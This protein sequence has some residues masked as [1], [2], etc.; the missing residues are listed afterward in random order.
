MEENEQQPAGFTRGILPW[1]V[2]ALAL[3][4]Y[5]VTLNKWVSINSLGATALALDIDLWN[6]KLGRPLFY[7]VA[8]PVK[9][10]PPGSQIIGLN[11]LSA[12]CAALALAQLAR[13]VAILPQDRTHEQRLRNPDPRGLLRSQNDWLP[14]V[15][16]VLVCGF[17]LSFWEQATVATG[18]MLNLLLF[19]LVIRCLAEFRLN[20]NDKWLYWAALGQGL[21]M[22][23]NWA[24]VG[25]LPIFGLAV[26]W[27]KGMAFFRWRF[28]LTG[29]GMML[30]GMLLYFFD[31][32]LAALDKSEI[33]DFGQ[34]LTWEFVSQ[35]NPL[36]GMP[37]GR[38][39]MLSVTS[40]VPLSLL[41]IR[42]PSNFGDVSGSGVAIASFLVRA[43]HLAFFGAIVWVAFD[44]VFSP[45][46]LG[47]ELPMLT[48]YYL[49]A[50][51]V[52]YLAGYFLLTCGMQPVKRW[53]QSAGFGKLIN[54]V[55]L[56]A[57]WIGVIAVP[58]LLLRKNLPVIR[59]ENNEALRRHTNRV[60]GNLPENDVLLSG[61]DTR[62]LLLLATHFHQHPGNARL[63]APLS[64]LPKPRFHVKAAAAYPGKWPSPGDVGEGATLATAGAVMQFLSGMQASGI[65]I[66]S[67]DRMDGQI[68]LESAYPMPRGQLYELV[69]LTGTNQVDS[70]NLL[71]QIET[72]KA[73]R[74][75]TLGDIATGSKTAEKIGEI[76]SGWANT[77]GVQMQ[78]LQRADDAGWAF[79]LALELNTNNLCAKI[80]SDVHASLATN[81]PGVS[82]NITGLENEVAENRS[83]QKLL[84][85]HGPVDE[86]NVHTYFGRM[87]LQRPLARQAEQYL[88][89]AL[90]LD[91]TNFVA[92]LALAEAQLTLR[93]YAAAGTNL[94]TLAASAAGLP[95]K[96]REE[97]IRVK[98][99]L[100]SSTGAPQ[101]AA[102]SLVA[103][104][105]EFPESTDLRRTLVDV[106][107]GQRQFTNA[108]PVL[109]D[110]LKALPND[111]RAASFLASSYVEVG[112]MEDALALFAERIAK[113]PESP[114]LRLNHGSALVRAKRLDEAEA[115]YRKALELNSQLMRGH[116]G[117]ADVAKLRGN[118]NAAITHLEA[119][120]KLLPPTSP[121]AARLRRNIES[122]QGN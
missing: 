26:L 13:T 51:M 100:E 31:P 78:E 43:V 64:E 8:I 103:G 49:G 38:V 61:S 35:R 62:Q 118:T 110:L 85:R 48:F 2:A 73:V 63:I 79:A 120:V 5:G 45:R 15:F 113:E 74:E 12:I 108:V 29:F 19:A 3:I 20:Q 10:L 25:F 6:Y 39:L 81:G 28:V 109:Q 97:Y 23:T 24:M 27:I 18:E 80:N 88:Q 94:L 36:L 40:I 16:A 55:L 37:K 30:A 98:A 41:A 46:N 66:W 102:Q 86:A 119:A 72:L 60:A 69:P 101:V 106:Y 68:L 33:T 32:L 116:A 99:I 52:G 75:Q 89:R 70:T 9:W 7:L 95:A 107:I 84:Q 59:V 93:N 47:Y 50:L 114:V 44:P 117:L 111:S 4:V 65:P 21:G 76:Y 14:P 56:G 67:V 105:K 115:E 96:Q 104:L 91:G 71:E 121:D 112:R 11:F 1:A 22:A 34:I 77:V 122:L 87:L 92:R 53:Q 90:Q 58:A 83:W 57:L 82:P 42:W 17:Q 54:N